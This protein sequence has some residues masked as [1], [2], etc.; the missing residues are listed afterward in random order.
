MAQPD[1]SAA[2]TAPVPPSPSAALRRRRA[3][4]ALIAALGVALFGLLLFRIV[5]P[6]LVPPPNVVHYTPQQ[7][8]DA[9]KDLDSLRDQLLAPPPAV[10]P[11]VHQKTTAEIAGKPKPS[12]FAVQTPAKNPTLVRLQL[13]Q[14]DLNTYLATDPKIKALLASRGV[15][16]VQLS[17]QAPHNVTCRAAIL[18]KGR[19]TNVQIA[20]NLL[21]SPETV[22]R[23][24][25]TSAQV[26]AL[27]LPP[28]VV[29][30]QA[31]R[32]ANQFMG[33]MRG[34]FPVAVQAVQ[35][36]GDRLILTGVRRPPKKE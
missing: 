5:G 20:G 19:Q 9:Q 4:G 1:P 28:R 13:S 25:A 8:A 17:L 23:F 33:R 32:I 10:A 16:T 26:G 3:T 36:V 35:V 18:Y 29:T 21:P 34:R 30:D 12:P 15:Q 6:K 14:A 27:P 2:E 22:A 24:E 31:N 7:A 11:P